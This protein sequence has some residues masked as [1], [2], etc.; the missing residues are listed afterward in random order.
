MSAGDIL[1]Q[2]FVSAEA[3]LTVAKTS[4]THEV[5]KWDTAGIQHCNCGPIKTSVCCVDVCVSMCVCVRLCVCERESW[6]HKRFY[7]VYPGALLSEDAS[8]T[9]KRPVLLHPE[10]TKYMEL[11]FYCTLLQSQHGEDGSY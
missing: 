6:P 2:C 1:P 3:T 10:E 7:L 9:Q 5:F 4:R 11:L 8:R